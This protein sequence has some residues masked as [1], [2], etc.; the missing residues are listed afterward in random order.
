MGAVGRECDDEGGGRDESEEDSG[1]NIGV[2]LTVHQGC[3]GGVVLETLALHLLSDLHEDTHLLYG[4]LEGADDEG[5]CERKLVR[6]TTLGQ[7]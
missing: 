4:V 1:H 5:L 6:T 2:F 3:E 7:C